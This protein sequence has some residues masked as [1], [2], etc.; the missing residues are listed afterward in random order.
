MPNEDKKKENL[1]DDL[2]ERISS[3]DFI[4]ALPSVDRMTPDLVSFLG[5]PQ[6]LDA[7]GQ[8]GSGSQHQ[9]KPPE[10]SCA[11]SFFGSMFWGS[12]F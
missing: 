2:K 3:P 11:Q 12:V 10:L 4:A 6:L 7:V 9:E 1:I 8:T 5:Q